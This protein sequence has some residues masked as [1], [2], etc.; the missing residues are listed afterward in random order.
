MSFFGL[1]HHDA[2]TMVTMIS[3]IV[4][5]LFLDLWVHRNDSD[6]G[7]IS[8][9]SAAAWSVFWVLTSLAFYG[10]LQWNYADDV[11]ANG[12]K[13]NEQGQD[14]STVISAA[15]LAGYVLEKCLS[16]DNLMVFIAVFTY[17][18][19]HGNM[20]HRVLYFG[21]LGAIVFRLV[22]VLAAGFLMRVGGYAD[23]VF[24]V[25]IAWSAV[26]MLSSGHDDDDEDDYSQNKIVIWVNKVFSV[27]PKLDGHHF[28]V[29]A[30]RAEELEKNDP[31]QEIKL[32]RPL[33]SF[34]ATPVFVC[35]IVIELSDVMF[36]FDSVPAVLGV[37]GNGGGLRSTAVSI[38]IYSSMIFAIL[39]LRS[40]YFILAVLNK[41]LVYL[42][43]TVIGLLFFI[44]A[45]LAIE[46]LIKF[47]VEVPH[48]LHIS[49]IQ[50]LWVVLG[51]L[52]VGIVASLLFAPKEAK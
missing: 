40:L 38:V 50:S 8:L 29:N 34:Y 1:E 10:F 19:L 47:G 14:V 42:E 22:F 2:V 27:F 5:S 13:L 17:F 44:A 20:Q 32:A 23:I 41:Y 18:R 7:E 24:A 25:I 51:M 43:K 9:K 30:K 36:A 33:S 31:E 3:V 4:F 16:V 48:A 39:G 21:I 12:L 28:F 11:F 6:D 46:A 35:L 49:P 26:K 15:F 52:S 37:V 45:K